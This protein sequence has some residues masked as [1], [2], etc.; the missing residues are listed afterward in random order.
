MKM[1]RFAFEVTGLDKRNSSG[2]EIWRQSLRSKD[3]FHMCRGGIVDLTNDGE[4]K[5]KKTTGKV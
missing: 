5:E 1:L 4:G 3:G 2:P